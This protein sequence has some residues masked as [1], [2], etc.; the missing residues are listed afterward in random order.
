MFRS[1]GI[2]EI[3][4]KAG[5]WGFCWLIFFVKKIK[6]NFSGPLEKDFSFPQFY[7]EQPTLKSIIHVILVAFKSTFLP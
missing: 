4:N 7:V 2:L 1:L 6:H 3:Q 5:F